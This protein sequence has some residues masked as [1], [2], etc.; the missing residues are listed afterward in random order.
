MHIKP[1]NN[2]S[3]N[4]VYKPNH[5]TPYTTKTGFLRGDKEIPTNQTQTKRT[6]IKRK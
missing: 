4:I 1:T 2:S 6:S 3:H 5:T